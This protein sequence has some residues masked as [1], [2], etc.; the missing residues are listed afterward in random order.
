MVA[1]N[2]TYEM[3][4][5]ISYRSKITQ[6]ELS[7]VIKR[8]ERILR[9]NGLKK[10]GHITTTTFSVENVDDIQLMDVE[11]LCPVDKACKL[12]KDF[13]FKPEFR[14]FNAAKI[15]YRGNPMNMHISANKL[16]EYIN[17]KKLVPITPIYNV[18]INEPKTP[19][20]IDNLVVD[21]YVD[22]ANNNL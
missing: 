10:S 6:A 7:K 5:V 14:L 19:Q 2:Q 21:M 12:P 15:T 8:L 3:K 20:D 16:I 17:E 18:T 11:I 9:D 1:L 4:N 22:I 13:T